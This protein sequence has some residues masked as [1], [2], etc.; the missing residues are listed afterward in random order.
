MMKLFICI[1]LIIKNNFTEMVKFFIIMISFKYLDKKIKRF[2]LYFFY[3][4]KD[5]NKT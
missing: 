3:L 5:K 2:I 4:F 1:F